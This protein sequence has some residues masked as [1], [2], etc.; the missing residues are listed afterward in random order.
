MT[1]MATTTPAHVRPAAALPVPVGRRLAL[2]AACYIGIALLV[3]LTVLTERVLPTGVGVPLL[4][5]GLAM[6]VAAAHP[7]LSLT[8][9]GR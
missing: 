2:S 9:R 1:G 4:V 7:S 8:R 5:A 6:V 3:A